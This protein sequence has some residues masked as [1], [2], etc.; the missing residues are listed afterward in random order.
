MTMS[1]HRQFL[2]RVR[3][4]APLAL[5]IATILTFRIAPAQEQAAQHDHSQH[6]QG[7]AHEDHSK[8]GAQPAKKSA[9]EPKSKAPAK[10]KASEKHS[11]HTPAGGGKSGNTKHAGHAAPKA[12]ARTHA[13][14]AAPATSD[15]QHAGHD[16]PGYHSGMVGFLGPYS[17]SREGSGTSWLPDTTPHEGI[18][19]QYGDWMTM[20]H[21]L[22]NGVYDH[23]G[24]PRGGQKTFASGM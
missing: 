15:Q 7:Q 20:W 3:W 18:H 8:H 12:G 16:M 6:Q 21:A 1:A 24:G 10:K 4:L 2:S 17:M 11:G 14:H 22:F 13:G 9:V 23:Q 19:G 5:A